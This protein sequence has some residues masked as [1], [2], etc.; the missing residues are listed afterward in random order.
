MGNVGGEQ[1]VHLVGERGLQGQLGKGG[2]V[3]DSET[4]GRGGACPVHD[5][6]ERQGGENLLRQRILNSFN[7]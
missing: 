5:V 2:G 4:E 3:P 6:R 1:V 7:L